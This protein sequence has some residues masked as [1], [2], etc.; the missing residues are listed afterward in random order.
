MFFTDLFMYIRCSAYMHRYARTPKLSRA[1]CD[2]HMCGPFT[3]AVAPR[4]SERSEQAVSGRSEQP[5]VS[6]KRAK[7][8]KRAL[9]AEGEPLQPP[10]SHTEEPFGNMIR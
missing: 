4:T 1:I 9:R 10:R 8:A 7:R 2:L 6:W 3:R 5:S